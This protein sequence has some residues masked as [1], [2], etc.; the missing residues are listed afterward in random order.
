MVQY[1]V[2]HRKTLIGGN[3]LKRNL[4]SALLFVA[5]AVHSAGCQ[6]SKT[7]NTAGE[8]GSPATV[9]ETMTPAA[10][11]PAGDA[12]AGAVS[13]PGTTGPWIGT[14][15]ETMTTAG[16]TYVLVDTGSEKIWAAAPSFDVK[17]GDS[18]TVP[19]GSP[20]PGYYSKSLDRTFDVINF[21][22]AVTVGGDA[23]AAAAPG[24]PPGIHPAPTVEAGDISYEG[25]GKADGGMTVAEIFSGRSGLG[26]AEITVRGKVVKF[27]PMIMGKNWIHLQDGT[28]HEGANDL[29]ITTSAQA[30]K[31]DTV[32]VRGLV[33]L[34]KDFGAGYRYDLII[35]D[36]DVTVE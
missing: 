29:T 13:V 15:A 14:V 3:H 25:I 36:A 24:M 32:L 33:T 7:V 10:V 4:V 35:E 28:D 8:A 2:I 6:E 20:M 12:G 21:V 1:R 9:A 11:M 5:V 23:S 31:G 19:P 30:A 17:V 27:S 22:A 16:Y 26:G 34:D 18:V